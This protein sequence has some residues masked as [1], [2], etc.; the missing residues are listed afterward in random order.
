MVAVSVLDVETNGGADNSSV[1]VGTAISMTA[2]LDVFV[3]VAAAVVSGAAA[4]VVTAGAVVVT[5]VATTNGGRGLRNRAGGFVV[6]PGHHERNH[7]DRQLSF[8]RVIAG[9]KMS[10]ANKTQRP[11]FFIPRPCIDRRTST[12]QHIHRS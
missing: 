12:T 2:S 6:G 8:R 10:F 4:V 5:V 7:I 9:I 3:V 1:E 11:E